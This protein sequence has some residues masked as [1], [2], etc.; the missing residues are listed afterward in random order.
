MP[1][2]RSLLNRF[3]EYMR[4]YLDFIGNIGVFA[5]RAA[6]RVLVSP[7][8]FRMIL[9]QIEGAGWKSLPLVSSSGFASGVV[10]AFHTRSTRAVL[11]RACNVRFEV[12]G[13]L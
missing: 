7:F 6:R 5:L 1:P 3:S 11:A 4:R 10:L 9:Q 8:E 12:E 13:D 2:D